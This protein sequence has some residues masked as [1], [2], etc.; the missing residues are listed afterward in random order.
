MSALDFTYVI[1]DLHLTPERPGVTAYFL[2][3]LDSS[4][5]QAQALYVLG[6]LFE[7]WIGDDAAPLIGA[8]PVIAAMSEIAK[9][10]PCYFI[11]GNRDFL[12]GEQFS[13]ETGF[14]ILADETV[15]E[16]YGQKTLLLHGDSL[17][18]E[19]VAHQQFRETMVT[20]LEWRTQFLKLSIPDR[21]QSAMQAREESHKH[22]ANISMEIMDVTEKSVTAAFEEHAVKQMI[23][24]HTHRQAEHHYTVKGE[25]VTRHVL[26]D[27]GA[28]SSLMKVCETGISI[29]NPAIT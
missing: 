15:I 17:C 16:L 10:I 27:W 7:Y 18:T 9:Q 12:V 3:F 4:A 1:S 2:D 6:D 13:L 20:N 21:I 14:T 24:G 8:E 5:K 25:K 19:D 22:K 29:S 11:A 26:G 28:T 23:H